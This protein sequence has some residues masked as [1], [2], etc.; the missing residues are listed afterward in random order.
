MWFLNRTIVAIVG[1]I[2]CLFGSAAIAHATLT[3]SWVSEG[4]IAN[5][6]Y[7]HSVATA[8]DVNGDGYSDLL[9]GAPGILSNRG[10]VLVHHGAPAGVG[11]VQ[12]TADGTTPSGLFGSAV[13][14]AGD[15][16]ADGFDDVIIG[17]PKHTNGQANEGRITVYLGSPAGL[18]GGWNLALELDQAQAILGSSVAGAGDVNGDG[19]D[20][21]LFGAEGWDG[22]F[23]N[24][25]R[26]VLLYGSPTGVNPNGGFGFNG[27][28]ASAQ[29]GASVSTAGD[30]NGDGY[31]DIVAGAPGVNRVYVFLG[32]PAGPP[33]APSFI[34]AGVA[35]SG[36]GASVSTA[37]DMN[38][39]GYA[40]LI[41]GAPDESAGQ[42][43]EGRAHV[44]LG[45]AS[46]LNAVPVWSGEGNVAAA[47][48]GAAV[49]AAGDVNGDG[50]ADVLVGAKDLTDGQAMEGRCVLYHGSASGPYPVAAWLSD[51]A[52]AGAHFGFACATAG[53]VNGDGHNDVVVAG[54]WASNPEVAEGRVALWHGSAD[55]PSQGVVWVTEM[56]QEEA[57]YGRA[58]A[59]GDFNGDGYAD[60]VAG[61]GLFDNAALD[62]VG[63]VW[64]HHGT[65][66][67]LPLVPSWTAGGHSAQ[68]RFGDAVGAAGDV[69]GDGYDD[70]LVGAP[71]H[72]NQRGA[73]YLFRGA[74]E[75]SGSCRRGSCLASAWATASALRWPRPRT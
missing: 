65:S 63:R 43:S 75:V 58:L 72:D 29:L 30:L 33:A 5:A 27:Q 16:D 50:Y 56:N 59:L 64:V 44:Y 6:L 7:G 53:D 28:A 32:G 55:P 54:P 39:D 22:A 20:D 21:V 15:V 57:Q 48:Y 67:G 45:S 24:G 40:D 73:A 61:T 36:F 52:M 41:V 49:S 11:A 68:D 70:L 3:G 2:G 60:A 10:R 69:N 8:G 31:D 38:G 18:A 71:Y 17:A 35:G 66:T 34:L 47:H 23:A 51:G 25:G 62:D 13:A 14:T 74:R 37:G 42:A 46:G 26:V 9:I 12:W 4:N 1:V 19:Y